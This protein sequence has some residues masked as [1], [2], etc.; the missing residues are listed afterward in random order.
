MTTAQRRVD[1]GQRRTRRSLLELGEALRDARISA[2]LS[3]DAVAAAA[4]L[5]RSQVSRL[6]RARIPNASVAELTRVGSVLG[7]RFAVRY[8]PEGPPMRDAGHARL[9]A[10]LQEQLG[11]GLRLRTEVP[12]IGSGD[13]R[14]WDAEVRDRSSRCGV[15][16]ETRLHDVQAM[17][18]RIALKMVDGRQD[19]VILLVRRSRSNR[20]ALRSCRVLLRDRF[21][22]DSRAILDDLRAGRIPPASGILVL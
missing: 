21:P 12:V 9:L 16:A 6:E 10:R 17:D 3:Q 5:S 2:D 18:R 7:L 14:A 8:F 20:E 4:L 11:P 1:V 22:L 15:E 13:A 19:R